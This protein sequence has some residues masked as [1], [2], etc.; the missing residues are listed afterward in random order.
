MKWQKMFSS[1][2]VDCK[3][4]MIISGFA[5]LVLTNPIWV[6]KTRLCLQYKNS[7]GQSPG[8]MYRGMADALLKIYKYEGIPGLYKVRCT[9]WK[10]ITTDLHD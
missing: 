1:V 6:T 8:M 4:T 2:N 10:H 7:T 3:Y 9:T 5:T